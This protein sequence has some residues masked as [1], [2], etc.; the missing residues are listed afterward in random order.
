MLAGN[1]LKS[2]PDARSQKTT[3]LVMDRAIKRRAR[4]GSELRLFSKSRARALN[5]ALIFTICIMQQLKN[6]NFLGP[7]YKVESGSSLGRA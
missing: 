6:S 4:V 7:S 2:F 5:D 3:T 1:R